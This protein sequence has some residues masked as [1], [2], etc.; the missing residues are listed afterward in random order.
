MNTHGID[1][2]RLPTGRS[3]HVSGPAVHRTAARP[4]CALG[5][6]WLR[7]TENGARHLPS[8]GI[9]LLRRR[10]PHHRNPHLGPQSAACHRMVERADR[11]P[12]GR[13]VD[14]PGGDPGHRRIVG[15]ARRSLQTDDRRR[16]VLVAPGH[17]P[18]ATLAGQGA[19]H[20][21]RQPYPVR[22]R[23]LRSDPGE[24][25]CRTGTTRCHLDV[26][27]LGGRRQSG[28]GEPGAD[29]PAHRPAGGDGVARQGGLHRRTLRAVP[30]G[31]RVL[32]ACCPSW[33]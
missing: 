7:H 23:R 15:T 8:Q 19:V 17:D 22:H 28:T 21:G 24:S 32:S 3:G 4:R 1:P 29:V 33:T 30:A 5:R 10:R 12:E 2:T 27:E 13:V 25:R 6:I 26:T 31:D 14:G 18:A 11:L 20:R 9:R 16:P